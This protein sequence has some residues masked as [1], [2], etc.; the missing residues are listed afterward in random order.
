MKIRQAVYNLMN[1]KMLNKRIDRLAIKLQNENDIM[2][3]LSIIYAITDAADVVMRKNSFDEA[4]MKEIGL[5]H[6][7]ILTKSG[8]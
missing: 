2:K 5:K 6:L 4:F 8:I 7:E 1:T 3:K